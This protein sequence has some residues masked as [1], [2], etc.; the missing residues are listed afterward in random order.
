[1]DGCNLENL[2]TLVSLRQVVN[3]LHDFGA[4]APLGVAYV[5][6]WYSTGAVLDVQEGG[7]HD[8]AVLTT[9]FRIEAGRSCTQAFPLGSRMLHS[10]SPPS[11][12][13]QQSELI[14]VKVA[15]GPAG[16]GGC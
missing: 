6:G 8:A 5:A 14:A 9:K 10:C 12:L 15:A 16:Q 11:A 3:S 7:E 13:Q 2:A 1:M 4:R